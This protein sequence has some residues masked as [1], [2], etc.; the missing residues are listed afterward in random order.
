MLQNRRKGT[1]TTES[2]E[3]DWHT[4]QVMRFVEYEDGVGPADALERLAVLLVDK[5]VVR[6]EQY[7]RPGRHK[8]P[9]EI[10][11]ARPD[12]AP[13]GD[14]VLDVERLGP[15]VGVPVEKRLNLEIVPAATGLAKEGNAVQKQLR[16]LNARW[17]ALGVREIC[18]C[19]TGKEGTMPAKCC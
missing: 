6:H 4:H 8:L 14:Q 5:I 9:R 13:Y 3:Q 10:I 16:K 19:A 2:N 12:L 17:V 18:C 11:R 15:K 1:S 7:L